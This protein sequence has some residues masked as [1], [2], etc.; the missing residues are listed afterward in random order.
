MILIN[1]FDCLNLS[2][3]SLIAFTTYIL[4]I[5]FIIGYTMKSLQSSSSSHISIN[6]T[7]T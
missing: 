5:L 3:A 2:R 6:L 1:Q 4:Y 7:F